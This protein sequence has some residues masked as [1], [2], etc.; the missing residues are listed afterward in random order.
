M[1]EYFLLLSDVRGGGGKDEGLVDD[2]RRS[3][4]LAPRRCCLHMAARSWQSTLLGRED[5]R[6]GD[7]GCVILMV[8]C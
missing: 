4:E 5:S 2:P 8:R 7:V 6:E 1:A 3:G